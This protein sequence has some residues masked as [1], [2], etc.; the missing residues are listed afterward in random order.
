VN[1]EDTKPRGTIIKLYKVIA[2]WALTEDGKVHFAQ[3]NNAPVVRHVLRSEDYVTYDEGFFYRVKDLQRVVNGITTIVPGGP[4]PGFTRYALNKAA[5]EEDH[6]FVLSDLSRSL[7]KQRD[8]VGGISNDSPLGFDYGADFTTFLGLTP[9]AAEVAWRRE[10]RHRRKSA[11]EDARKRL[12]QS[13][14][15]IEV[16]D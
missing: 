16:E 13:R 1:H 9:E 2:E 7:L 8:V 3:E 14:V 12:E 4:G 11:L 10:A 6:A 5:V 15:T